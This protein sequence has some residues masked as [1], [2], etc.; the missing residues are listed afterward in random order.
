M[1]L[2]GIVWGLWGS[3][4]DFN[5][6]VALVWGE[7]RAGVPGAWGQMRR[8]SFLGCCCC[9]G[10][11]ICPSWPDQVFLAVTYFGIEAAC[12]GDLEVN[13]APSSPNHSMISCDKLSVSPG[14]SCPICDRWCRTRFPVFF[15]F[16]HS[17]AVMPQLP[18]APS[19]PSQHQSLPS[20]LR[21]MAGAL[22]SIF[23]FIFRWSKYPPEWMGT[24]N[25]FT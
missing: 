16:Q 14:W 17:L 18:V 7:R 9:K 6:F 15:F 10:T 24:L 2:R 21:I 8:I 4:G 22:L 19:A 12:Q 13:E 25:P 11:W 1:G 5:D 20:K 3:E 23:P